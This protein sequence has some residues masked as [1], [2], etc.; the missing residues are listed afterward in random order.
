MA[1]EMHTP[2]PWVVNPLLRSQICTNEAK[3]RVLAVTAGFGQS[4][5]EQAATAAVM[6]AAPDLLAAL[7]HAVRYFDQLTPSDVVRYRIAIAKATGSPV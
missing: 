7:E 5:E 6:A 1:D 3:P 2:G 4:A